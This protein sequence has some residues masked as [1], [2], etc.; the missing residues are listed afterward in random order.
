MRKM[1]V[2]VASSD[3]VVAGSDGVAFSTQ[4]SRWTR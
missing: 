3:D 2:T 1:A 4:V